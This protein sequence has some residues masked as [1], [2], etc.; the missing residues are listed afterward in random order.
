MSAW[1]YNLVAF[2]C[3]VDQLKSLHVGTCFKFKGGYFEDGVYKSK[4]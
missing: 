4:D 2:T 1:I 3:V